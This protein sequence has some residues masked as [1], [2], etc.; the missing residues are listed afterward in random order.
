MM[1][2]KWAL[3]IAVVIV[4]LALSPF[5]TRLFAEQDPCSPTSYV[6]NTAG[7]VYSRDG[8]VLWLT[9]PGTRYCIVGIGEPPWVLIQ[10]QADPDSVGW[11]RFSQQ[12]YESLWDNLLVRPRRE[13]DALIVERDGLRAER[14]GLRAER[15]ALMA[16]V[17]RSLTQP[18]P[19]LTGQSRLSSWLSNWESS[20]ST[21]EAALDDLESDLTRAAR[22]YADLASR[23]RSSS[24]QSDLEDAARALR[25]AAYAASNA[26]SEISDLAS[27]ISS[28]RSK[29]IWVE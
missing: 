25:N 26:A 9:E 22:A 8:E 27:D 6:S 1:Y 19:T 11:R 15:D 4:V 10:Q 7:S 24:R 14:D 3:V 5:S 20:L 23:T 28:A 13:R 29:V 2:R 21:W 12:S 16:I 18:S 17:G